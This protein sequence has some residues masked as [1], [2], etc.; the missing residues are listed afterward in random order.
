MEAVS[1]QSAVGQLQRLPTLPSVLAGLLDAAADPE[2]SALEL[3]KYIAAD[4]S[5]T[6]AL[7]R[8]V[9]SASYGFSRQI[10]SVTDAIVLLGFGEVRN[11]VL[12]ASAFGAVPK[13]RDAAHRTALWRHALATAI[14]AD[15]A[16]RALRWPSGGGYYSAG[17]L[18]DIGK[19]ALDALYP[20]SYGLARKEASAGRRA[21][22]AVETEVLGF[23]HAEAGAALAAHWQL[24]ASICA[25]IRFHHRPGHD[26]EKPS[27]AAL[28]ALADAIAHQAG[29]GDPANGCAIE[30]LAVILPE[31]QLPP[32]HHAAVLEHVVKSEGRIAAIVGTLG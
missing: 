13:G 26:G 24:P 21:V 4:Q 20:Q 10:N 2:A 5:L 7:L 27:A 1:L 11:L 15:R 3:G 8:L 17:L 6:A 16:A 18:H 9:N 25:A 32:D 28:I 22:I 29:M 23:D 12:T 30:E 31:V 19:V 14:A